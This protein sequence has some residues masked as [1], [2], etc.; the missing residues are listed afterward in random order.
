M[1]EKMLYKWGPEKCWNVRSKIIGE[2]IPDNV[3][4]IDIGGGY[5]HLRKFI[6]K[7]VKYKCIDIKAWKPETIVADFNKNQYPNAGRHHCLVCQGIIEYIEKPNEFLDKIK[8]YGHTML[9]TYKTG[10]VNDIRVNSFSFHRIEKILEHA[11]WK[12]LLSR[13][14]NPDHNEKLYY[15]V[16]INYGKK[17]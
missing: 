1:K 2:I 5:E 12:I 3:S 17:R 9:I 15:C 13:N 14:I 7:G 16:N 11:G 4:I 6:K 8:K 10:K